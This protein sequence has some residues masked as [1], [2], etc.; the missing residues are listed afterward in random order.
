MQPTFLTPDDLAN[1]WSITPTTLSQW[2]WN[3]RGP[4]FLKIGRKVLYDAQD[5]EFFEDQKRHQSTSTYR[6][7]GLAEQGA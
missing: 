2:R 5:V 1:R 3:G 4:K 7:C 6:S